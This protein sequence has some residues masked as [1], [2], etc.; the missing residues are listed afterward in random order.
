MASAILTGNIFDENGTQIDCSFQAYHYEQNKWSAV[1]A[2]QN[3]QYSI[4][5]ADTDW[6]TNVNTASNSGETVLIAYWVGGAT[7]SGAQTRF[8]I[9]DV[10]LTSSNVYTNDVQLK[11]SV[12]PVITISVPTVGRVNTNFTVSSSS[13]DIYSWVY[14]VTTMS[15]TV[16]YYAGVFDNVGVAA[17]DY[18]FDN[19]TTYSSLATGQKAAIG[20]Y[21]IF[22][23]ATNKYGQIAVDSAVIR[24]KYRTPSISVTH[25]P[26]TAITPRLGDTATVIVAITDVDGRLVSTDSTVNGVF[27]NSNTTASYS[28]TVALVLDQTY[29]IATVT[30][31]N[32]GYAD[33]LLNGSDSIGLYNQAPTVGLTISNVGDVYTFDSNAA[34]YENSLQDVTYTLY[35]DSNAILEAVPVTNNWSQ[36][37]SNVAVSSPWTTSATFYGSGSFKI[38]AY[39]TDVHGKTSVVDSVVFTVSSNSAIANSDLQQVYFD[40]E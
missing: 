6:L 25:T 27:D 20:D 39:A 37:S 17:V 28:Y 14:G 31:W 15:H 8:G 35:I 5:L 38:E 24:V 7:R 26:D 40:W 29:T 11:P 19:E 21:T 2:S 34:D 3:G 22:A 12:A 23:R 18:S 9:M 4:D 16:S 33:Q 1:R 32:D 10:Q 13:N 30:T 36:L